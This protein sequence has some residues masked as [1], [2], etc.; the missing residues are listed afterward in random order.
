MTQY[1]GKSQCYDCEH[2]IPH[3]EGTPVTRMACKA[4]PRGIPTFFVEG[5]REHNES[6]VL[7]VPTK[8]GEIER[9]AIDGG[10][11]FSPKQGTERYL[12]QVNPS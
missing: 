3:E 11:Y 2:L 10:Y 5:I 4:F 1:L 8:S 9:V 7:E 6:I 12:N